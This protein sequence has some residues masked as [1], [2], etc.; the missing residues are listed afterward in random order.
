[1]R[2]CA[3]FAALGVLMGCSSVRPW[4]NEPLP[5]EDQNIP[6]RKSERDPTIL[7]AV[8]LS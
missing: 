4:I 3:A 1:M 7:V 8:T 5:L 6:V 2:R